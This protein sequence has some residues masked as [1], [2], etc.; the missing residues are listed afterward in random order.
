[1]RNSIE[2]DINKIFEVASKEKVALEIN[3]FPNRMDLSTGL[4]KEDEKVG[5]KI[6]SVGTDAHSR[7]HLNFMKYGIKLLKRAWV[8]KEEILNTYSLEELKDLL[9]TRVH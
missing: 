2:V 3:L 9:W 6:F 1:L 5:S 4:I 7:G 8:K